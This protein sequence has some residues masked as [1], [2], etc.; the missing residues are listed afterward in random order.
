ML[1]TPITQDKVDEFDPTDEKSVFEVYEF[2]KK[3]YSKQNAWSLGILFKTI[4]TAKLKDF[5]SIEEYGTAILEAG[6]RLTGLSH[7]VESWILVFF[8]LD[9]LGP[10]YEVFRQAQNI[11]YADLTVN[12]PTTKYSK[13]KIIFIKDTSGYMKIEDSRAL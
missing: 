4:V 8:F 6:K 11:R 13:D 5:T 2:L 9:G 1:Y 7:P 12:H 3:I 10:N